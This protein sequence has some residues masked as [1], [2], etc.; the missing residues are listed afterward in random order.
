MC[1]IKQQC[2]GSIWTTT[3]E[4]ENGGAV[5]E[6]KAGRCMSTREKNLANELKNGRRQREN[7][8]YKEQQEQKG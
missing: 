3:E 1:V 5:R 8:E 7:V 2:S 6:R 4:R